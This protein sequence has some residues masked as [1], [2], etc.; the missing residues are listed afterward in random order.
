MKSTAPRKVPSALLEAMQ[1]RQVTL[2]DTSHKLEAFLDWHAESPGTGR[3][4]SAAGAQQDG[5][6]ESDRNFLP[7]R[8]S[9]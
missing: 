3:H 9:R 1:E 4:L 2:G 5:Y 8:K 6:H 7:S